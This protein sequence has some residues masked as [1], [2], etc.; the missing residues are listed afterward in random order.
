MGPPSHGERCVSIQRE[1]LLPNEP[2][3]KEAHVLDNATE[4]S[5]RQ[6]FEELSRAPQSAMILDY[7][8]TLC[9]F[10]LD[11]DKAF[12]YP[13]VSILL[14]QIMNIGHTRVVLVTGRPAPE[15]IAL[16]GIQPHPE[17]WGEYGMQRLRPD[18]PCEWP[19]VN[20][21]AT[22]ALA[23]ADAWIEEL[24]LHHLAEHKPGA[25]ALHWRGLPCS[26]QSDLRTLIMNG[27]I[28]IAQRLGMLVQEFDGGVEMR[29]AYRNKADAV[30]T[31]LAEMGPET[32][33]TYL[34]DDET[35]EESFSVLPETGIGVLVRSQWRESAAD[36]WL[37][38]PSDLLVFLCYWLEA[39][40]NAQ[41]LPVVTGYGLQHTL[42]RS[43]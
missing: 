31:V 41:R 34:G 4:K 43:Q 15:V 32:Q 1:K 39:C 19:L 40:L 2:V 33:V 17:V 35:D 14:T 28:P 29:I 3:H 16:L 5:L 24:N 26:E 20:E 6:F 13:G 23:E 11:R 22:R 21:P 27:W 25:L 38:P 36:V 42:S 30:R 7:D 9:P 10:Q 37:E 12:P 8:G 18:A